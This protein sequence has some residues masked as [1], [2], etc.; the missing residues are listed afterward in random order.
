MQESN[1]TIT[2]HPLANSDES[3]CGEVQLMHVSTTYLKWWTD[4]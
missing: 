3:K 4:L 1:Q 2:S